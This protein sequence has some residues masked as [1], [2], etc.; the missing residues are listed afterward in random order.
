MLSDLQNSV[1]TGRI[2]W[3]RWIIISRWDSGLRFSSVSRFP[4]RFWPA[5][6]GLQL[7]G[8]TVNIV[9]LF[10]LILAVGMLVDDA[11]ISPSLP[12]A[13]WRKASRQRRPMRRGQA[14]VRSGDC[15]DRDADCGVL[16]AAVLA[17]RGRRVMKYLP[18][19][20]IATLSASLAVGAVFHADTRRAARQGIGPA[21]RRTRP[22]GWPLH[23][24]RA[25][26]AAP[27]RRHA[28]ACGVAACVWCMVGYGKFRPRRRILPAVEPDSRP[29]HR[30][31]TRQSGARRKGPFPRR[32][33][34][35][36]P[37]SERG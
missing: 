33:R 27:A 16:A 12:S 26:G 14:H 11:I 22:R 17:G 21:A 3:S 31:R 34:E 13:G 20:L 15:G 1:I 32:G 19:T 25:A 2:S 30:S 10:S 23:A 28:R 9:V 18:I 4:H 7:A 29:G 24:D 37:A 5:C 36:R 8:L 6:F 35:A